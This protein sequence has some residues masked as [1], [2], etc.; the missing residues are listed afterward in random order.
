MSYSSHGAHTPPAVGLYLSDV[1]DETHALYC[2]VG[3]KSIQSEGVSQI[4]DDER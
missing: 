4:N 1:F 2:M 3:E